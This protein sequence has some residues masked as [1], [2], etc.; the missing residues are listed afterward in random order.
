MIKISD[1]FFQS[2]GRQ[3]PPPKKSI[4]QLNGIDKGST[5]SLIPSGIIA[6]WRVS[7]MITNL[8][9]FS[10]NRMNLNPNL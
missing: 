3:I 8:F 2:E 6:V 9:C 5:R 7:H 10:G 1:L 4:H